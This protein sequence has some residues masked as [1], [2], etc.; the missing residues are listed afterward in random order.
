MRKILLHKRRYL[1]LLEVLVA[2]SIV[3]MSI[4]P[5][6]YPHV[7]IF[8]QQSVY[9][10]KIEMNHAVNLMFGEIYQRLYQQEIPLSEI[11]ES[12]EFAIDET[13]LKMAGYEGRQ[14]FT[15]DY[16]FRL[17]KGKTDDSKSKAAYLVELIFDLKLKGEEPQKI[18]HFDYTIFIYQE[19]TQSTDEERVD[20]N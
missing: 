9:T 6:L 14:G 15:G 12:R 19:S 5:L 18:Y 13:L 10:Q 16:H 4:F 2:F 7:F 17:V 11:L 8:R 1:T 20:E 3:V